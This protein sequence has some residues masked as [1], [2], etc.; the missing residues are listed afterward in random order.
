MFFPRVQWDSFG[1]VLFP[2]ATFI[3][4]SH[5]PAISSYSSTLQE[6]LLCHALHAATH[7][8]FGPTGLTID[9]RLPLPFM[10]ALAYLY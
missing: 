9:S 2:R 6:S 4:P 1:A 10:L 8:Q 3:V 5:I 7:K